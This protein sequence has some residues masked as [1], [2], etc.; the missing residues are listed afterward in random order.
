MPM[1]ANMLYSLAKGFQK[2]LFPKSLASP[3]I[4]LSLKTGDTMANVSPDSLIF[5]PVV[6]DLE[7]GSR[8]FWAQNGN[9]STA[10]S[11]GPKTPQHDSQHI[12]TGASRTDA[13]LISSDDESDYGHLDED[14][15]DTSFPSI[16]ELPLLA[17]RGDGQSSSIASG[18]YLNSPS[19]GESLR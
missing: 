10:F 3:A 9:L 16:W 7:P 12:A 5:T 14:Q 4:C 13:F 1:D 8:N 18:M 11:G 17:R 2:S 19:P 15:S 6:A